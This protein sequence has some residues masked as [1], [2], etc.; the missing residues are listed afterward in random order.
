MSSGVDE[1][2]APAVYAP[3][4]PPIA[5]THQG[6]EDLLQVISLT[7]YFLANGQ[8]PA[9]NAAWRD[10]VGRG[11]GWRL[12]AEKGRA[13]L[14]TLAPELSAKELWSEPVARITP[15]QRAATQIRT[16]RKP[17]R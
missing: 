12:R 15:R 3:T 9:F 5:R 4:C 14:M 1:A 10:A 17:T 13:A 6:P 8:A 7:S 16:G 11:K 2:D